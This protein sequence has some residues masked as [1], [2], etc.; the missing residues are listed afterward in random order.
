MYS[1]PVD[2]RFCQLNYSNILILLLLN[3]FVFFLP[4]VF[5]NMGKMIEPIFKVIWSDGSMFLQSISNDH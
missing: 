4:Q 1:V 2:L 5:V 3:Y